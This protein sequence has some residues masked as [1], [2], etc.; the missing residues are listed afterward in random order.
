MAQVYLARIENEDVDSAVRLCFDTVMKHG[1]LS[2]VGTALI[3]PNWVNGSPASSGVTTDFR[4]IGSLVKGLRESGVERIIVGESSL[5]NTREVFETLGVR[6][7]E[8]KWGVTVLNFDEGKWVKVISPHPLALGRF[9]LPRVVMDSD[10]I[11][12][13]GKMKTHALTMVTLNVKNILGLVQRSDRKVAHLIDINKAIA[14]IFSYLVA[15]KKVLAFV[16]GIYALEGKLGPTSGNS[17]KMDLL[18]AGTDAVAVDATCVEIMGFDIKKVKHLL[19]SAELG[20]G[21]VDNISVTG[22]NLQDVRRSFDMPPLGLSISTRLPMLKDKVFRK[23][24]YLRF[25]D[26]CVICGRCVETCPREAISPE[27]DGPVFDER[28]CVSCL[29]CLEACPESALDYLVEHALIYRMLKALKGLYG[30]FRAYKSSFA[31][32]SRERN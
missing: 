15:N 13:V 3:K 12:S 4:V 9:H 17:V 16:D 5:I 21:E 8:K 23:R 27:G 1:T 28:K 30:I 26:R 14:E 29:C 22:V 24:P 32:H 7:W 19:I 18:V 31:E 20:L 25:E 6:E 10:L 2:D 11:V